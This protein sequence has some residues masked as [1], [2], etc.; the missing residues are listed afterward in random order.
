MRENVGSLWTRPDIVA[1]GIYVRVGV[2]NRNKVHSALCKQLA[3]QGFSKQKRLFVKSVP[4][5]VLKRIYSFE[6]ESH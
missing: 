6:S 3:E 4:P 5:F 1:I 2:G